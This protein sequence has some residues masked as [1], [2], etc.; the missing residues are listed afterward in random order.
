MNSIKRILVV[1]DDHLLQNL[2][3]TK[4]A[5]EGYEVE[6][7]GNG[8]EGYQKAKVWLPDL[9]ILDI[10]MPKLDGYGM[11]RLMRN[12]AKTKALPV[13]LLT[14]TP[15]LPSAREAKDLGVVKGLFKVE[16]TPSAL[17]Q[18]VKEYF[19]GRSTQD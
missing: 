3:G 5:D 19:K 8:M 4:F 6:T 1:E 7:A 14:N 16:V 18:I 15:S 17:I 9:I 13:M 12:D 2:Y 11:L 10:L